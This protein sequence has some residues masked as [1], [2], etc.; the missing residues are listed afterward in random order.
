MGVLRKI[1]TSISYQMVLVIIAGFILAVMTFLVVENIGFNISD[2]YYTSDT[3]A[4][5]QE[6]RYLTSLQKYISDQNIESRDHKALNKWVEKQRILTVRIYRDQRIIYDSDKELGRDENPEDIAFS[7]VGTVLFAD[8]RADV[9]ID[10]EYAFHAYL[11]TDIVAMVLA[12]LILILVVMAVVRRW[13]GKIR[14]LRDDLVVLEGGDLGYK[15]QISGQDEFSQL[16]DH[17]DQM[18]IALKEQFENEKRMQRENQKMIQEMSHNLKTPLTSVLLYLELLQMSV[19]ANDL[20]SREYL[21]RAEDKAKQMKV[22]TENLFTYA[23]V[24]V[25]ERIILQRQSFQ[26]AFYD[27]LSTLCQILNQEGVRVEIDLEEDVSGILIFPDYIPR[28]LDNI[29]SNL[30]KY[31]DRDHSV[32]LSSSYDMNFSYMS[33]SH[34]Q[35]AI[36]DDRLEITSPGGL[37]P[38]VTIDRMKER[39]SKIR[40]KALAHAFLYMNMIEE[41]GSGIPRLMR[42][43]REYELLEPQFIDMDM[44][45]RV[46]LYRKN[47]DTWVDTP[48]GTTETETERNETETVKT[49]TETEKV[50]ASLTDTQKRVLELLADY[51]D[52]TQKK[53]AEEI[54][55]SLTTI[56]RAVSALQKNGLLSRIGGNKYGKWK[57]L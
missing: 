38:G 6:K 52:Y 2:D 25:K 10:G 29:L 39:F 27:Q 16:G 35:V 18:R 23:L 49:E 13:M 46:N 43:M 24:G 1:K 42:Q 36:F 9:D 4:K 51:P 41:W 50:R 53:F 20:E 31:S 54:G 33:S 8:G 26:T 17:V 30:I 3:Y 7:R 48:A 34:I 15:V 12:T 40:N 47:D 21:R 32:Y 56:K 5:K 28:I 57:V 37:L 44:E 19:S 14:E 55:V 11:V 45:F 22:Q